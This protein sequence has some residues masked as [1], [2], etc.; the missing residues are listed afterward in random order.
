MCVVA[1]AVLL[2]GCTSVY[3]VALAPGASSQLNSS[4]V[5]G[6]IAVEKD[7]IGTS[8]NPSQT[9]TAISAGVGGLIGGL[10]GGIIDSS[11]NSKSSKNAEADVV[12]IR[13]GLLDY[14]FDQALANA[15]SRR[16]ATAGGGVPALTALLVSKNT[17]VSEISRLAREAQSDA[18]AVIFVKHV[19]SPDFSNAV[20]VAEVAVCARS[21]ALRKIAVAKDYAGQEVPVLYRNKIQSFWPL[22]ATDRPAKPESKANAAVWAG[23][24]ADRLRAALDM[25]ADEIAQAVHWDL[26]EPARESYDK[27][28]PG[29]DESVQTS[30][31]TNNAARVAQGKVY[32]RE[33]N[34]V[35]LRAASGCVYA[36]PE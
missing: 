10:I 24:K 29:G 6:V 14:S 25:A 12:A 20:L 9:G 11:A 13:D 7:E 1:L 34:R 3:R 4:S 21:E 28:A 8:I 30:D 35:W 27:D 36:Q 17:T 26:S 2:N 16:F 19:M 22:P 23:D 31:H 33:N 5:S 15:F 32:R 18:A